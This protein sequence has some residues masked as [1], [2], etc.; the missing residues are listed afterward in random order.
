MAITVNFYSFAKRDNSTAI[1][2]AASLM[3]SYQ[4]N[5]KDG[6]SLLDPVLVLEHPGIP[7]WSHFAMESR[8]YKVTDIR[9]IRQG[10][11][12]VSG[13][14]DVLATWKAEILASSAFVAYDTAA[15]IELV[16][17]RVSMKSTPTIAVASSD[18]WVYLGGGICVIMNVIS[19]E[20]N[21]EETAGSQNGIITFALDY[22][23][24]RSILSNYRRWADITDPPP[25]EPP[26]TIEEWLGAIFDQSKTIARNGLSFDDIKSCIQS[27]WVFPSS[28]S[29]VAGTSVNYIYLGGYKSLIGGKRANLGAIENLTV[30]I[31]WQA[32]DWRRNAPYTEIV[33]YIPYVGVVSIPPSAVLGVASLRVTYDFNYAD[34]SGTV[35]VRTNDTNNLILFKTSISLS[36]PFGI[37]NAQTSPGGIAQNIITAGAAAAV[38][39]L[40]SGSA[41]PAIAAGAAGIYG[42]YNNAAGIP[43]S[44]G[45][46]AGGAIDPVNAV[47]CFVIYHDTNVDPSNLSA[48][49]GTPTMAVKSLAGMSGYV[50]TRGASVSGAMTDR[51]RNAINRYLDGGIYIE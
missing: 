43:T 10:L 41:A 18:N 32:T 16:D 29:R 6:T 15:N 20:N 23:D 46:Y 21:F 42:I 25:E 13:T 31:P 47:K 38:T 40:T 50:E 12:E 8:Y 9:S 45:S 19:S 37:G 3:N 24:A 30:N 4:C 17:S 5:L 39:A 28:A 49:I 51:E 44:I 34:G 33:L 35:I 1:P 7:Y 36:A 26:S 22:S 14:V 27:A 11:I 48:R 2:T